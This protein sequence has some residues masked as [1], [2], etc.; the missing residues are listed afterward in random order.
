MLLSSW[1]NAEKFCVI[2]DGFEEEGRLWSDCLY[3]D[4]GAWG[5]M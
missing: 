4:I 5:E 3:F 1:S 2:E